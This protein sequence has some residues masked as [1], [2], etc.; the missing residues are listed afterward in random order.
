MYN[1]NRPNRA[2]LPTT[3]QLLRSTGLA[4]LIAAALLITA[5][6]PAEFGIDP[7]GIG[8]TLGL[9]QM[10]D[11][12]TSLAKEA[13][14]SDAS[15]ASAAQAQQIAAAPIA[16]AVPDHGHDHG[17]GSGHTHEATSSVPPGADTQS[18]AAAAI[19]D[20]MREHTVT[21]SLKPG[22][23]AEIK[24]SMDKGATVRYEWSAEGGGVNYDTHGDPVNA[25]KNFY[26]GYGKGRNETAQTGTLQAAFDG[27]HGWFWRN[28]SGRDVTVTL[29]T[30]GDYG[31]IE[32]VL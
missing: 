14:A 9:T 26:H 20:P 22:Q 2:D 28:R 6:L 17:A 13:Q 21:I 32:R 19:A 30:E 10:G 23:A 29:K 12:K 8:R 4:A 16:P 24:L 27:K 31:Q 7:T 11:I 18:Q 5:I 25:P 15:H 1:T 3:R